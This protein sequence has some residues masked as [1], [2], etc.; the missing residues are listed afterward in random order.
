[1]GPLLI[2]CRERFLS[3]FTNIGIGMSG[4]V[5][6]RKGRIPLPP[7]VRG[8]RVEGKRTSS[9]VER[10]GARSPWQGRRAAKGEKGEIFGKDAS[11]GDRGDR[12]E[13]VEKKEKRADV[14]EELAGNPFHWPLGKRGGG[15]SLLFSSGSYYYI[16]GKR[17]QRDFD[18]AVL[19]RGQKGV[20]SRRISGCSGELRH[21]F[22]ATKKGRGAFA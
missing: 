18:T 14:D 7:W 15:A 3:R 5:R 17:R 22:I 19:L 6:T 12:R 4:Q 10:G 8:A 11:K 16:R 1:V 21:N 20:T 9:A 2:Y 13:R